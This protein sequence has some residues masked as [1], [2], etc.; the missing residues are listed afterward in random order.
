MVS[1]AREDDERQ[2][3]AFDTRIPEESSQEDDENN[4]GAAPG[5][6]RKVEEIV[7]RRA[8]SM[9]EAG[10]VYEGG[11][12]LV[13]FD[14]ATI[15]GYEQNEEELQRD[16]RPPK[17]PAIKFTRFHGQR[18]CYEEWKREMKTSQLLYGL[19]ME[20]MAGLAYMSL[21]AGPD[22]PRSLFESYDVDWLMTKAGFVEMMKEVTIDLSVVGVT[23][24]PPSR[25]ERAQ[26]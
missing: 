16:G 24:P 3:A 6:Q 11:L 9:P 21:D 10:E 22:K 18:S 4:P 1:A 23:I 26:T 13:L 7:S 2:Q 25:W 15:R 12:P 20:Q 19:T 17:L 5:L 8:P 14:W